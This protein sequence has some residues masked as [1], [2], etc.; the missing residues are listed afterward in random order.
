M[1]VAMSP[2]EEPTGRDHYRYGSAVLL[3][4]RDGRVL[5]QERDDDVPPAGIGRWAIPGGGRER[6][7]DPLQTAL[8]E[9]QEET[10]VRLSRLRHFATYAPWT[11][12]WMKR[13]VLD[14]FV[15]EDDVPREAI[16]VLEGTDFRYWS[17]EEALQLLLNPNTR[18]Y[19][20]DLLGST[21]IRAARERRATGERWVSVLEIDR[22]GRVLVQ[23]PADTGR[24]GSW[25]LP[26]GLVRADESPDRAALRHFDALTGHTLDS[27]LLY[28][29]FQR[30][31]TFATGPAEMTHV[32]YFDADLQVKDLAGPR[33]SSLRYIG[34][35]DLPDAS[36]VAYAQTLLEAFF[37]SPAYRAMFH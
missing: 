28:R 2:G 15:A 33:G 34:P 11:D 16:E 32:Y 10:T 25:S 19:L 8:R 31:G 13:F 23:Q 21:L 17:P 22:W 4:D 20:E 1:A 3:V 12:P 29:S 36:M 27:L 24:P 9:F 7:E 35:E 30:E 18:Q 37:G 6:D 26:G 5:L 14:V